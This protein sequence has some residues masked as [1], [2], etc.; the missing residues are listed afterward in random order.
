MTQW[1]AQLDD[2]PSILRMNMMGKDNQLPQIVDD[3][4]ICARAPHPTINK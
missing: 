4:H 1:A 2:V 3:F